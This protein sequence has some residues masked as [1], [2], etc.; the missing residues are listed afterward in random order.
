M[1]LSPPPLQTLVAEAFVRSKAVVLLL[2]VYC[3][4]TFRYL[5]GFFVFRMSYYCKCPVA[6]PH[7]A[8]SWSVFCDCGIS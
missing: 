1:H 5:S 3:L 8:I 7:A 6:I 2:L 4:C